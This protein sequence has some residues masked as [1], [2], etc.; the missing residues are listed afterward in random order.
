MNERRGWA[1]ALLCWT[2]CCAP[3]LVPEHASFVLIRT[4]QAT[5]Q[6]PIYGS[7]ACA[8]SAWSRQRRE[9]FPCAC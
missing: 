6:Q 7:E 4:L 3:S 5:R 1:T 9:S 2:D 8:L